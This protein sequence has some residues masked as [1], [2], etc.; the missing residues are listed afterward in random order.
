[1]DNKITGIENAFPAIAFNS[2][3]QINIERDGL[4]IRQYFAAMAMQGILA[5]KKMLEMISNSDE[6]TMSEMAVSAADDLIN[7]LNKMQF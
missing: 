1:M 2:E 6:H 7:E 5:N 4:T 3:G